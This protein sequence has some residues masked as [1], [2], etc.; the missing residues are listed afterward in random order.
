MDINDSMEAARRHKQDNDAK[1]HDRKLK[2]SSKRRLQKITETKI[3]TSFIGALDQFEKRFGDLWGFDKND[4]DRSQEERD[5][6]DDYQRMR[7]AVLDLGNAQI[8]ALD[9]ELS[10]YE[11]TWVGYKTTFTFDQKEGN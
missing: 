10:L 5:N 1:E 4:E 8:R 2:A 9:K 6:Y 3:R 7:T 11:I